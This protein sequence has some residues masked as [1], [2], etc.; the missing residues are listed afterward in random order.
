AVGYPRR[1]AYSAFDEQ[2]KVAITLS[3]VDVVHHAPVAAPGWHRIGVPVET[4]AYELTGIRP[5]TDGVFSFQDVLDAVEAADQADEIPYEGIA[6]SDQIRKRILNHARTLYASDDQSTV[7]SLGT[8]ESHA[9]PYQSYAKAFT[10]A[11]LTSALGSRATDTIL[12]EGG[13]VQFL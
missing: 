2:V 3:E 11:L 1:A 13:Y 7:L 4:R 10:P 12:A 9:L 8:I 6:P 5:A